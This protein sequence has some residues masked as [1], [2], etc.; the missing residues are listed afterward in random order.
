[1][2]WPNA[3][4]V[5]RGLGLL[6]QVVARSGPNTHFLVRAAT[7]GILMNIALGKFDV[8]AVCIRRTDLL[9]ILLRALPSECLRLG[10]ELD[11]LMQAR[12]KVQIHFKNG[13]IE[14]H[15]ALVGADGS[16]SR[17]RSELFGASEPV[18]RGYVN[19]RGLV[20]YS[21]RATMPGDTVKLGQRPTVRNLEY[22]TWRFRVLRD[23]EC[24]RSAASAA[25]GIGRVTLLGDAAYPCALNLGPGG[26]RICSCP[27]RGTRTRSR[28]SFAPL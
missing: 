26:G 5:L 8:P 15:A 4:R 9:A 17:V 6:D 2:L 27:M 23:G 7:G 28:A 3:T 16:R 24:A 1:M 10:Y 18:Y 12:G 13:A 21:G 25:L 19:W 22:R 14:E 20:R 11:H